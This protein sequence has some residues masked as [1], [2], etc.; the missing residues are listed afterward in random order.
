MRKMFVITSIVFGLLLGNLS[1]APWV[2]APHQAPISWGQT[3]MSPHVPFG[4]DVSPG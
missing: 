3:H 1:Q 4:G 2:R